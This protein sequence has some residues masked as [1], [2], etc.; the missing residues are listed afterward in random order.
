MTPLAGSA[1]KPF[2]N[3]I[4][5]RDLTPT[6]FRLNIRHERFWQS[7]RES[8]HALNCITNQ[9]GTQYTH[10]FARKFA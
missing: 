8:F 10:R 7:H 1:L 9:A 5:L 6:R 4:R 2:A 3:Y